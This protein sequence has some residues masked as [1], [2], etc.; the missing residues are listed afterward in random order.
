MSMTREEESRV[1]AAVLAG[2]ADR[3]GELVREHQKGIY[4]HALRMLGSEQDA[5]D[6]SQ[7]AFFRAYRALA[8]FRG[9][10]RFSVWLYKLAGNVCLDMLRRRPAVPDA[11][12]T[13][14]DAGEL[15]VPDARFCPQTE[16]EK[17]ELRQTVRR[18]VLSLAPEFRQAL[19][20]RDIDGLS[21]DE[22]ARVTGLE[23]GTVKSRIF[24]AR[25]KLAAIL[26]RDGNFSELSSSFSSAAE[27]SKK[28]GADV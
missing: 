10:S 1:I 20:L 9:E 28:G 12:L 15:P 26:M 7:E 27:I 23:A 13:D 11:S 5:L 3:F 25:K 17:K 14:E 22:I 24:R 8:S 16:L 4:N 2:E 18:A 19:I 6:A 21:Y